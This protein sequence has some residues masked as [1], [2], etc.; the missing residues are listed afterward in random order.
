M[1]LQIHVDQSGRS[2]GLRVKGVGGRKGERE[3]G[4]EG[5]RERVR[6]GGKGRASVNR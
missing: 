6:K 3:E 2:W 1:L 4:R 5:K